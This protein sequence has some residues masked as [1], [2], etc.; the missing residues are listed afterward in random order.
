MNSLRLVAGKTNVLALAFTLVVAQS[1]IPGL[2]VLAASGDVQIAGQVAFTYNSAKADQSLDQVTQDIQ[3]KLNDALVA[4]SDRSP[5]AVS[6][7]EYNGLPV[8]TLGGYRVTIVDENNAKQAGTTAAALAKSWADGIRQALSDKQ[9]VDSYVAQ[10]TG[11]AA[12]VAPS[13]G[14]PPSYGQAPAYGQQPAYGQAQPPYGQA[15]VQYGQAPAQYGQAPPQYGQAP[16]QYGQPP[17]GYQQGR[18]VY[19]PAGTVLPIS[20]ET[21]ISTQVARPGDLIQAR[22]NQEIP[23]GNGSIPAG[24]Q[25]T[26]QITEARAGGRLE[27]SG[28]LSITFNQ[29]RTPDGVVTPIS[30]HIVGGIGKYKGDQ[31]GTYKGEGMTAKFGQAAIRGGLGAGLGAGL[32]TAVGAIAGHGRGAGTGAWSGAAIGGG[33]G[34]ADSLVLRKGR[35]VV[36]QSGTSM[37]LQLDS[38]INLS[39]SGSPQYN[40]SPASGAL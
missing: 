17:Y 1:L 13:A 34:L 21:S 4:S 15:P 11:G 22:L 5:S 14:A 25:F 18:V 10:L 23:L 39:V 8:I 35:D 38:P 40:Q 16:A 12:A 28:T 9:R 27:R 19:A 6:I 20:L 26:G 2:P 30:A 36:I 31:S 33:L 3:N 24:S 29:L 7:V 32:G 37:Q